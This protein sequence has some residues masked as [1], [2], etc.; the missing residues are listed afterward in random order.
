MPLPAD[1]LRLAI[2]TAE[3]GTSSADALRLLASWSAS[4]PAD[5]AA[6][7]RTRSSD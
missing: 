3:P 1:G 4:T 6:T 5:E 7:E 2:F